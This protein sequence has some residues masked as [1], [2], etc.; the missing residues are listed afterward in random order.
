M[1]TEKK[2]Y[3]IIIA[4]ILIII[5][6]TIITS[7][8]INKANQNLKD[9]ENLIIRIYQYDVIDYKFDYDSESILLKEIPFDKSTTFDETIYSKDGSVYNRIIIKD[10]L[11][12]VS[13]ANCLNHIC[14]QNKISCEKTKINPVS[15]TCMPSGLYIRLERGN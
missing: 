7:M 14:M 4:M 6:S 3:I 10:G 15:I 11:C 1:K 9:S 8:L 5:A 13:E 12:Y 2:I